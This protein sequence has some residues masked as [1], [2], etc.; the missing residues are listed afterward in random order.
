MAVQQYHENVSNDGPA[1]QTNLP[2]FGGINVFL[3]GDFFQLPPVGGKG[4]GASKATEEQ[5]DNLSA[6]VFIAIGRTYG[7]SVVWKP[8]QDTCSGLS[9]TD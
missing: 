6:E 7:S 2:F 4:A 5:A 1:S 3:C 9:P 8:G